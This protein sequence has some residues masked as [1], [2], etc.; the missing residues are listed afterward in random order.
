MVVFTEMAD[1]AKARP[2]WFASLAAAGIVF[3]ILGVVA[4]GFAVEYGRPVSTIIPENVDAVID[5]DGFIKVPLD[6]NRT[7]D[8][9]VQSTIF[10]AR[11]TDYG[12]KLGKRQDLYRLTTYNTAIT[13]VGVNKVLLWFDKPSLPELPGWSYYARVQDDCGSIW[14]WS[15]RPSGRETIRR[16]VLHAAGSIPIDAMKPIKPD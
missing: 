8:C 15:A 6:I 7:T 14:N 5:G 12:G 11:D 2:F 3:G 4:I 9:L 10:L 1:A 13:G 16:L